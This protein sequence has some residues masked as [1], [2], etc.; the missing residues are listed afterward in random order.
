MNYTSTI[1]LNMAEKS[2]LKNTSITL[3]T[4][5]ISLALGIVISILLARILGPENRGIYAL[6]ILIPSFA[7]M[8]SNM[9]INSS[10]VFFLGKGTYP[11]TKVAGNNL[12]LS[13]LIGLISI[14]LTILFLYLFGSVFFAEVP[15]YAYVIAII[16][17]PFL[18]INS[19]LS[20]LF[21]GMHRFLTYN[22]LTFL[23]TFVQFILLLGLFLVSSFELS[24][25]IYMYLVSAVIIFIVTIIV[26]KRSL[27]NITVSFK[28]KYL[29]NFL[30]YGSKSYLGNMVNFFHLRIDQLIISSFLNP[31]A[32]GLYAIAV[33]LTERLWLLAE[34]AGT[35]LFPRVSA[36]KNEEEKNR[37]TPILCR[38]ILFVT[39]IGAIVLFVIS[40]WLILLFYSNEYLG[41]LLPFQILL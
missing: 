23:G 17:I 16:A 24:T 13:G 11:A 25:V 21:L 19:N 18:I 38:N 1:N 39:T 26:T 37:F 15:F 7:F 34:S 10:T 30:S 20:S 33:G 14:G 31:L 3:M 22:V 40:K 36:E 4:R 2:F 27:K 5:V 41:S 12:V 35:I 28:E 29:K 32:I 8:F 6:V 9:G